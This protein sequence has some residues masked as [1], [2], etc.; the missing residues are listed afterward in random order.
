MT[1]NPFSSWNSVAFQLLRIV[2]GLYLIVALALTA[3]QISIDY[4][5]EKQAVIDELNKLPNTFGPG[6]ENAL[7]SYDKKAM[8]SILRGLNEMSVVSGVKVIDV[9]NIMFYEVGYTGT[10]KDETSN[11]NYFETYFSREF[12][13]THERRAGKDTEIIGKTIIFSNNRIVFDRVK[14]GLLLI[15]VNSV[16]KSFALWLIFFYFLKKL[17]GRPLEALISGVEKTNLD[18]LEHINIQFHSTK[19]NEFMVLQ[20]VYNQMIDK[21]ISASR[22]LKASESNYRRFVAA[23]VEGIFCYKCDPPMPVNIGIEDQVNWV[24]EHSVIEICNDVYAQ[25]Q[26]FQKAED[27]TGL[28][29]LEIKGGDIQL[30]ERI[31]REAVEAS[32]VLKNIETYQ[33]TKSGQDMWFLSNAVTFFE[34]GK[35]VRLWGSQLDITDHKKAQLSLQENRDLL[36]LAQEVGH[37]GSWNWDL[38]TNVLEWSDETYRIFSK[39]PAE[40]SPT[41][42]GYFKTIHPEDRENV[43]KIIAETKD[44]KEHYTIEYRIILPDGTHRFIT[45]KGQIRKDSHLDSWKL[46]ATVQNIT[47]LK[48]AEEKLLSYQDHLEEMVEER[49]IAYKKARVA[50]D[51]ANQAKSAFLANMSHEI[52]TP[53]N[54]II[55]FIELALE[56][57]PSTESIKEYLNTARTSAKNLLGLI[58]NILDVSKLDAGKLETE[59]RTFNIR[60]V[61]TDAVNSLSIA[62]RE[63]NI[64]LS[65]RLSKKVSKYINGDDNRLRQV[66]INLVGNA[67]KFT[68]QGEVVFELN[69]PVDGLLKFDIRDTGIGMSD[70]QIE[71]VFLPFTQADSSTSR[72]YGGTGLGTM[73]CKQLVELMG[74]E[75]SVTS[76]LGVGTQF[77]FTF[78]YQ[79][80]ER[81]V[82]DAAME[83]LGDENQVQTGF[84]K[85][86]ILLAEDIKESATLATIRLEQN[87]HRTTVV[88]DGSKAVDAFKI[89]DYDVILMDVNM[90]GTDGLE[91]TRQIRELEKDTGKRIPIIALTASVMEE[92]KQKCLNAG[93]DE[94]VGKPV[95]FLKLFRVMEKNIPPG[96]G[97]HIS[98]SEFGR[99]LKPETISGAYPGIDLEKGLLLWQDKTIYNK[100]LISFAK[101]YKMAAKHIKQFIF[102]DKID[103]AKER[104]H[105][106]KGVSGNLAITEVAKYA[107]QIDQALKTGDLEQILDWIGLLDK[108]LETALKSIAQ[109]ERIEPS[110]DT[111][112]MALDFPSLYGLINTLTTD[113]LRG[114][115]EETGMIKL[116]DALAGHAENNILER[117]GN[118]IDNYDFNQAG[119]LLKKIEEWLKDI[120]DNR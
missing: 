50:A 90:P 109:L 75:I 51:S 88:E 84:R 41:M 76:Q 38:G 8:E 62:A 40:Y 23:S 66:I 30:A 54:S 39:D 119:L 95:N 105:A 99:Q 103:Q 82:Y 1:F 17:L 36:N 14:Y 12:T 94:V 6:I 32:P 19:S 80:T 34:D 112:P 100:S 56:T 74:G 47:E 87:S 104:V 111:T 79:V 33:K 58:N 86:N 92:E 45:E 64:D 96:V 106:L 113:F 59:N 18:K 60:Q 70:E 98:S 20:D 69:D 65:C 46:V 43:Q 25:M 107:T 27:L 67:V 97:Q 93:M 116:V 16:V 15:I 73:I 83:E 120:E 53:M 118:A 114:E 24:I 2:F 91:A 63:K 5:F 49:T 108:A 7:W 22:R 4:Q 35:W 48:L 31:A 117:L 11:P 55:G 81:K 13:I 89:Q 71:N 21:L 3:I 102:E 101:N 37:I 85:F 77:S 42:E 44:N 115:Y 10:S 61:I 52:R 78:P 9:E 72:K 68:H 110:S 28:G 29:F 57:D 26:G